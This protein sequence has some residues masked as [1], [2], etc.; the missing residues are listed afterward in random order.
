MDNQQFETG[1]PTPD[2][3]QDDFLKEIDFDKFKSVFRKSIPYILVILLITN[4]SA[5]MYIRYTKPVFESTSELKLDIQ[6]EASLF[7]FNNL[8]ENNSSFNNL[9]G[10][11]ELIR[12]RLFFNKVIRV[13]DLDVKYYV[14]GSIL[15]DERYKNS[16]FTVNYKIYN[17]AFY[18]KPIDIKILDERNFR[19]AYRMGE[20]EISGD[21][22]FGQTVKT[23][24]YEFVFHFTEDFVP[25]LM[26]SDFYF[27]VNSNNALISYL[28][29]NLNVQPKNL[30]ANTIQIAFKDHNRY[31]ARDLVNAIDTLYLDY[32]KEEK[33]KAN[34]QKI[35][36]LNEQLSITEGRLDQFEN[37]FEDFTIANKT[38]DLQA[39]I[40]NTIQQMQQLDSQR[41]ELKVRLKGLAELTSKLLA[42]DS[43]DF[44]PT[45]F[46]NIP[47]DIKQPLNTFNDLN[48]DLALLL[49]SYNQNTFAVNRK[50][51]EISLMKSGITE[52]VTA[53]QNQINSEISS[54]NQR[55]GQLEENFVSLPAKST[56]FSKS[57]RGYVLYEEFFLS[58]MQKKNEF[59][60]A[61]AGTTTNFVILSSATLPVS[62]I[63]PN[64]IIVTGIGVVSGIIFSLLF[65]GTSYLL[66][67]KISS[68][69]ELEKITNA[70]VLGIVPF[71]NSRNMDYTKLVI[72]K[73]PRAAISEALRSIRTNMEFLIANKNQKLISVTSTVSGE[74]KTFISVNLGAIIALSKL[75][76]VVVDM[77]MRRPKIHAAF[78][79]E[80]DNMGVSTVLIGKHTATESIRQTIVEGLHYIPAGP[81][82]PNPSELIMSPAFD[83]LL[84]FLKSQYDMIILDTP[85]VGLV[86]DGI[87]VMKKVDLPIYVVRANYSKKV[88]MRTLNK[89]LQNNRFKNLS[90]ILNSMKSTDNGY[91]GYGGYGNPY[92][93][94][95]EETSQKTGLI[96]KF[97]KRK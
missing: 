87:L 36:F 43:L 74:G 45:V 91:G 66:H 64:N 32:T 76:T 82:P 52:K 29:D 22:V 40:G 80:N 78:A 72:S 97:I 12:S 24:D 37:Y 34:A 2:N 30:S 49:S 13:L 68:I 21:Y 25:D 71:Y 86:T 93:E 65:L 85:P 27:I 58:L 73:N 51:Q 42:E 59:E 88:F 57:R 28:E 6:R 17:E 10:E 67:N 9:S 89:L 31:K 26:S 61:N 47:E 33:K 14:Y 44:S 39:D 55:K 41:F 81:T 79:D 4:V 50:K 62:P 35:E 5:Y 94:S 56:E 70:P 38:T 96:N 75:K 20:E 8:P 19:M 46:R 7:G 95:N 54:I 23:P 48:S 53:Y 63:F 84:D 92:Y 83:T 15:D 77:D 69:S 1:R 60:I 11:I 90:V 18:D 16:P 3:D